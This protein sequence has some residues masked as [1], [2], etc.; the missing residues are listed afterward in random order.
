MPFT[1]AQACYAVIAT[2]YAGL[3]VQI[4]WDGSYVPH[5]YQNRLVNAFDSLYALRAARTI[6][7]DKITDGYVNVGHSQG[8][9]ASWVSEVLAENSHN[10]FQDLLGNYLGT[11]LFAPGIDA[12]NSVPKAF[13]SWIGKDPNLM[14]PDFNLS[15][16]LSPLDINRTELLT[17]IQGGQYVSELLFLANATEMLNPT[18][19]ESWYATAFTGFT[20]P[21]NRPYKAPMIMFQ[22]TED[23]GTEPYMRALSTFE[24]TCKNHHS[25]ALE[26]VSLPGVSPFS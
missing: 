13:C 21:G 26:F 18:W 19:N 12:L 1:L 6:F 3:G 22:G 15:D 5:Q 8:G 23:Q 20:N 24:S 11:I 9:S 2:D 7:F 14:Y 17:Q 16:W 25:G 4:S 10:K